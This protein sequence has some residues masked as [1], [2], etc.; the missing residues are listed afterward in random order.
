[1][2][3]VWLVKLILAHFLTDFIFQPKKWVNHKE[4]KHF[5]SP[6]LYVHTLFTAVLAWLLIGWQYWPTA[7]VIFV[8]HTAIDGWKSY[9]KNNAKAFIIDQVM[10]LVV[11]FVCWLFTFFTID[12]LGDASKNLYSNSTILACLTAFIIITNPAGI[13]I[14]KLTDKWRR[15]L[16]HSSNL[17]DAGKW[18]GII[19]R[20]VILIFVLNGQFEAIGLLIAAKSILRFTDNERTEKK[21]EYLLIG[22]LMSF[23]LAILV[24]LA[25]RQLL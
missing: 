9:Q 15:E 6:Y 7:I 19:E 11:I 4:E 25:V 13:L 16:D 8:T 17:K 14:E 24:G 2:E 21:T 22:T 12:V 20:S 23:S 3:T 18:I 5:S 1:M 10:H